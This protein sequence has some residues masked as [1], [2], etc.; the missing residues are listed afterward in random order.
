[1]SLVNFWQKRPTSALAVQIT[2][3]SAV[4]NTKRLHA[5]CNGRRK[6]LGERLKPCCKYKAF[7]RDV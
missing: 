6:H 5:L 4:A 1:M 3:P 2:P 7:A